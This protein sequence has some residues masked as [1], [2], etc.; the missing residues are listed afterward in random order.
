MSFFSGATN[1]TTPTRYTELQIQT[2]AQG[3]AV[4]LVW[5]KTRMSPN[6][7]WFNN[8]QS[9]KGN[10]KGGG[11]KG[12]GSGKGSGNYTYSAAVI[13]GLCEGPIQGIGQV[14][15]DRTLTTL[16]KIGLTL[17]TGA[18]GQATWSYLSSAYPAQALSYSSLAYVCDS[19]YQLGASASLPNHSFEVIGALS[20]TMPNFP[21]ANP[22]DII[23]DFLTNP[24]YAIGLNAAQIDATSLASYKTYCQAQG[25]LFSP[26]LDTQEQVSEIIDRWAS[27]SNSWI[28][29][30][31]GSLVF[32]PLGDSSVSGN[33]TAYVPNLTVAYDLTYDDFIADRSGSGGPVQVTRADPADCPNHVKIEIMDRGN[34]Y[35]AAPVEWQDQALVDQFGQIDADVT[36][37][38]EICDMGIAAIVSQLV[39]QRQAYI[40]NIYAFTLGYEFALLEPGDLVSLSDAHIGL[41]RFPVRIQTID[42]DEDGNL[43]I[44]AEEF[45]GGIGTAVASNTNSSTNVPIDTL[46]DP[47]PVNPPAIFEPSSGLTNGVAQI[48]CAASGGPNWGGAIVHLSFDGTTYSQIGTI[49][50]PAL[51]GQLTANLTSHADP[52]TVDTLAIDLMESAGILPTSATHAD[53]DAFRTLCLLTPAFTGT[54]PA[55]GELIAYGTVA[56]TGAYADDLTYLRRGL[57]GTSVQAFSSGAFVT[58]VQQEELGQ[59]PT[60]LLA[61]DLPLHYVGQTIYLKFQSYNIF[62]TSLED[63]SGVTAYAYSPTGAGYGGGTG[64]VPTVPTGLAATG[65]QGTVLLAWAANPPDDN[66]TGYRVFRA[67]GTGQPFSAAAQISQVNALNYTDSGLPDLAGYTYFLEAENAAGTSSATSGVDATTNPPLTTR[68][69]RVTIAGGTLA[70]TATDSYVDITNSTASLEIDLPTSGLTSG[71]RIVVTDEG[72]NAAT[73]NWTIKNG[74][75]VVDTVS[76]NGGWSALRWNGANWLRTS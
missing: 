54:V 2:S 49:T 34:A 30:S 67:P 39:G 35:N 27:L 3:V 16:A 11:G 45:P 38:H 18:A 44:V 56:A 13:L 48:W 5:G 71:Q 8:F 65:G 37:A 47:G 50:A 59:F 60:S 29:W 24:Q 20:G 1:A 73:Y 66:V 72:S 4:A 15:T 61:Y 9:H 76:V 6:I 64:G 36:E 69:R 68:G 75:T 40:R 25:L 21:D 58:R 19:S 23:E 32:V 33:G 63:I 22:A 46:V 42:E 51:Q 57:Y 70:L 62:G 53:A 52:D 55:G 12:G 31:G 7:V 26:V 28:F 74:G 41:E 43:A 14:W 10:G 17:F